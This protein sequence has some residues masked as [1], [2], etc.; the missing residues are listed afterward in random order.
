MYK[1]NENVCSS[2][3]LNK[4][5]HTF[6]QSQITLNSFWISNEKY[7]QKPANIGMPK[8]A[9]ELCPVTKIFFLEKDRRRNLEID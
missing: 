1:Q 7:G 8:N 5:E 2:G 3:P 9:K 6:Y 4:H